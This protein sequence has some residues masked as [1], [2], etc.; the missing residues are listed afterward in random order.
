MP[1]FTFDGV[2]FSAAPPVSFELAVFNIVAVLPSCPGVLFVVSI[3]GLFFVFLKYNIKISVK[4]LFTNI[5]KYV[6]GI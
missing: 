6:E 2:V 1:N 4:L 3:S 5:F